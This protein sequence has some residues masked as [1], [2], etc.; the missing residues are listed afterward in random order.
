MVAPRV[1][2]LDGLSRPMIHADA[3][4]SVYTRYSTTCVDRAPC[5]LRQIHHPDEVARLQA[6]HS[7]WQINRTGLPWMVREN[8]RI[9]PPRVCPRGPGTND[10]R[11]LTLIVST[12]RDQQ[13]SIPFGETPGRVFVSP[14]PASLA[15]VVHTMHALDVLCR[16]SQ[17][18]HMPV[19]QLIVALSDLGDLFVV[20]HSRG[21]SMGV[22]PRLRLRDNAKVV[23][24]DMSVPAFLWGG[25]LMVAVILFGWCLWLSARRTSP[26]P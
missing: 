11:D 3:P 19:D 16:A 26:P 12:S 13:R 20:G 21:R 10:G 22:V 7:L 25:G 4:L 6:H 8:T 1:I 18:Y 23:L 2:T 14:A 24:P 15:Y 5:S 9:Q 17:P